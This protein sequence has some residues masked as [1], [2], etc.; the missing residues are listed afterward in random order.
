MLK[1]R[2]LKYLMLCMAVAALSLTSCQNLLFDDEDCDN[3]IGT[4]MILRINTAQSVSRSSMSEDFEQ[5]LSLRIILLDD[6]GNVEANVVF[7]DVSSHDFSN[8]VTSDNDFVITRLCPGDKTLY[9][10]AN[11]TGAKNTHYSLDGEIYSDVTLTQ[12]LSR[13][14]YGSEHVGEILESVWFEGFDIQKGKLPYTTKYEVTLANGNANYHTVY[15]VPAA[16]KFTFHLF[17]Y[18]D[19]DVKVNK[20]G[21][22]TIADRQYLLGH[23]GSSDY[24]KDL[25]EEKSL[26]WPDWLAKIAEK[27]WETDGDFEG[28]IDFNHTFGWISNYTLPSGTQHLTVY[29][30]DIPTVKP[31]AEDSPIPSQTELIYLPES[32]NGSPQRYTLTFDI[33]GADDIIGQQ[34][35]MPNVM[36]L[37]RDTHVKVYVRFKPGKLTIEDVNVDVDPWDEADLNPQYG[38]KVWTGTTDVDPWDENTLEPGAGKPGTGG[39]TDNDPWDENEGN[40]GSGKPGNGGTTDND[41]WDEN[42]GNPGSGKPGNGGTTD[43]DPWD[44]N[45]GNPGSGKPGNGGTTDNDP[46][47][48]NEGNPGSGKPG[49]GG[50]TDNDPWDENE[51]NPGS[52]KPGNGGTTDNDPWDENEGNPGSGKPGNG[53][54][55]DNDPWDENEGNPG[56]GKPGNGSTTDND[57]W[58]GSE[59]NPP[60]KSVKKKINK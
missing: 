34:Y 7:D 25:F 22:N 42:E 19:E 3:E 15:L 27:S 56:A 12:L 8:R 23:V 28:N 37:F 30:T 5:I 2:L 44:E 47:D 59:L 43:N 53:G 49:S 1:T 55:T 41:P 54:T 58:D 31:V 57:P 21:I 35:E 45:E 48:E 4:T 52:G 46:W 39:T 10:I 11:E 14:D 13:I 33:D 18:R 51:G 17:N 9:V 32:N 16:V 26:Y 40:P 24:Y 60:F 36:A 6:K 50:T 29:V 38:I 20:I